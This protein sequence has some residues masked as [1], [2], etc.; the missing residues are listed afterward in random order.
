MS[1][2]EGPRYLE[3]RR[4]PRSDHFLSNTLKRVMIISVV[5]AAMGTLLILLIPFSNIDGPKSER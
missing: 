2:Y 3:H 5:L 4:R 1:K